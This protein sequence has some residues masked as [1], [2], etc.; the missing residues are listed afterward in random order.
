MANSMTLEAIYISIFKNVSEIIGNRICRYDKGEYESLNT[1]RRVSCRRIFQILF[2]DAFYRVGDITLFNENSDT[3]DTAQNCNATVKG[4]IKKYGQGQKTFYEGVLKNIYNE[5]ISIENEEQHLKMI[6]ENS[7]RKHFNDELVIESKRR[8][9]EQIIIKTLREEE[10]SE[11][12]KDINNL[13]S[14]NQLCEENIYKYLALVIL[15]SLLYC[16]DIEVLPEKLKKDI[17]ES[18]TR[19]KKWLGFE[20][21]STNEEMEVKERV[22]F[23]TVSELTSRGLNAENIAKQILK[24]DEKIYGNTGHHVGT[25]EQWAK[26]IS[27]NQENWGFLCVDETKIIGNYSY[28]FLTSLQER[29]LKNGNLIG[30]EIT[31]RSVINPMDVMGKNDVA[32]YLMNLSINSPYDTIENWRILY[33]ELVNSIKKLIKNRIFIKCIYTCVFNEEYVNRFINNGFDFCSAR[34][35]RGNFYCLD[36][37]NKSPEECNWLFSGSEPLDLSE[38]KF[39][40]FKKD[41]EISKSNLIEICNLLFSTDKHIYPAMISSRDEALEV[42]AEAFISGKDV[43]FNYENLF[44]ALW[45]NRV[46]GVILWK[47]GKLNWTSNI[48]REIAA[49]HGIQLSPFLDKVEKEYFNK[50]NEIDSETISVINSKTHPNMVMLYSYRL[51]SAMMEAFLKEHKEEDCTLYVL[52]E[53]KAEYEVYLENGYRLSGE[54]INGFSTENI[55]LPCGYMIRKRER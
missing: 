26:H 45:K 52:R 25:E 28:V 5:K 2:P 9:I 11:I 1:T 41:T 21:L 37:V 50:Y 34:D 10:F 33:D 15:Y 49:F 12:R 4:I 31:I 3:S 46:V 30:E 24:N 7:L 17:K 14:D 20:I 19:A 47:K 27:T 54:V 36:F 18:R 38:F 48:V 53:T 13:F 42:F 16:V 40:Q 51:E 32:L 35:G 23:C 29:N 43:M 55:E 22:E 44:L 6:I 8:E 39:C